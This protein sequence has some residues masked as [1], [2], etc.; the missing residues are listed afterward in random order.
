MHF[1]FPLLIKI[2]LVLTFHSL[3]QT[4]HHYVLLFLFRYCIAN[5]NF[6][7]L[8]A[9]HHL[10]TVGVAYVEPK[11]VNQA[12]YFCG[13]WDCTSII[14]AEALI[15]PF[16]TVFGRPDACTP[17]TLV[18]T[19]LSILHRFSC[20]TTKNILLDAKALRNHFKAQTIRPLEIKRLDKTASSANG[21]QFAGVF[22]VCYFCYF[23]SY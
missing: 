10:A 11:N 9:A 12:R 13:V 1:M 3:W 2:N 14:N 21:Y 19:L 8:L 20:L 16:V 22:L 5:S 17:M 7:K 6:L 23:K 4:T 15:L 18:N